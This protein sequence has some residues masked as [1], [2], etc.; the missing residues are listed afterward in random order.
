MTLES[1]VTSL[2]L[3]RKLEKLGVLGGVFSWVQDLRRVENSTKRLKLRPSW[4]MRKNHMSSWV[5]V[6]SAW[7][8]AELGEM[9]KALSSREWS[10]WTE[11][12][13]VYKKWTCFLGNENSDTEWS[14]DGDTEA[15][16][17]AKMLIYLI[18]NKLINEKES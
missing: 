12:N 16:A 10:A 1:Q 6:T 14:E 3:S 8:V 11:W 15:D 4:Q 18:E 9:L 13:Y 5:I 7:T 2:E 17:R